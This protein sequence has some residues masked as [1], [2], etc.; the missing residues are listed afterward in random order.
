MNI[1]GSKELARLLEDLPGKVQKKVLRQGVS[2]ASTPILKAIRGRVPKRSGLTKKSMAR[3]VKTYKSGTVV[4]IMGPRKDAAAMYKG[5]LHKP[6]KI[7]H[8]VEKGHINR[9]GSLTPPHPF[10]R[11]AFESTKGE[12]L[13]IMA[14]KMGTGIE[15]E[16][17]GGG[18]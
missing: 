5:K 3:K 8:L 17:A 1:T 10:M 13:N 14:D 12:A 15:R 4:S 11:P 18:R 7:A 2:A 16:A 9:D 6:S